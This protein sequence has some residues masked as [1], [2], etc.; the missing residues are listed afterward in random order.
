M[1]ETTDELLARMAKKYGLPDPAPAAQAQPAPQQPAPKPQPQSQPEKRGIIDTLRDRGRQIDKAS[2]FACGGKIHKMAQGGKIS[3]PGTPTS[4]S[5][6][7][8]VRQTGE[9]IKVSTE[10]RIL[11]EAQ[12]EALEAIATKMGFKSLDA[13]L[14]SLTGV[15]VGPTVQGGQRAAATGMGPDWMRTF[16]P[17]A[18]STDNVDQAYRNANKPLIDA[19][20]YLNRGDP[21]RDLA[22]AISNSYKTAQAN[23]VSG[24]DIN[25]PT[26]PQFEPKPAPL[27]AAATQGATLPGGMSRVPN[28]LTAATPT[29]LA[30]RT[31]DP[32]RNTPTVSQGIGLTSALPPGISMGVDNGRASYSGTGGGAGGGG[33]ERSVMDIYRSEAA[34]RGLDPNTFD[35]IGGRPRGVNLADSR[36]EDQRSF[37]NFVNRST[38]ESALAS[39][40]KQSGR[41]AGQNIASIASA[42]NQT[43]GQIPGQELARDQLA[44]QGDI[45]RTELAQDAR[46][47]G[48]RIGVEQDEQRN[49]GL[50]A[51]LAGLEQ[52]DKAKTNA[53]TRQDVQ[54]DVDVK[55]MKLGLLKTLMDPNADPKAIAQ[56]QKQF[57]ALSGKQGTGAYEPIYKQT[58][59]MNGSTKDIAGRFNKDTGEYVPLNGGQQGPTI[60]QAA[61]EALRKNPDKAGDFDAYYG[62]GAS[63]NY[64]QKR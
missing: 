27:A 46:Y 52:A 45:K 61:I 58:Q 25:D 1:A 5:I 15:P 6:P 38:L 55:Q 11:S 56:A 49:K 47:K 34:I 20:T 28:R 16:N 40:A 31:D 14:E 8:E 57:Q 4:D 21:I 24:A 36:I 30:A 39:A 37:D 60:P 51:Q 53:L 13:W 23:A 18:D 59:D 33:T 17:E 32:V 62:P 10:E 50:L 41:S 2:G 7:A 9:T 48:A 64:L 29:Y 19:A 35:P 12:D 63:S 26:R 22:G 42:L 3:G 43:A 44:Q 54:S